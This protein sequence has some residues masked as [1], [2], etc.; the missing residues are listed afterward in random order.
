MK[1]T[2]EFNLPEEQAEYEVVS[3][4]QA[5]HAVL[6][7][8]DEWLRRL[9]KYETLPATEYDTLAAVREQLGN[10]L[11]DHSIDLHE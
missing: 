3:N 8:M 4:A 7:E 2:L 11:R 10:L 9:L 1:A 5:M 6:F